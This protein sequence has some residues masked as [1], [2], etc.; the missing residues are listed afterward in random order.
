MG[1]KVKILHWL[2]PKTVVIRENIC[3]FRT[4]SKIVRTWIDCENSEDPSQD[5]YAV[6]AYIMIHRDL[7]D[8]QPL[9]ATCEMIA[10]VFPRIS[11]IEVLE[12]E[13]RYG[14]LLYP[15]WP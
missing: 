14:C 15:R 11:A 5:H 2:F 13:N 8:T 6:Q 10:K 3:R 12:H 7:I 4:V 1:R 9:M